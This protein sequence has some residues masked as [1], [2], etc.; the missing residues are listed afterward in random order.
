MKKCTILI[1][2]LYISFLPTLGN[3]EELL[4]LH[5][6]QEAEIYE[7]NKVTT[8]PDLIKETINK[9]PILLSLGHQIRAQ[10]ARSKWIKVHPDPNITNAH[11]TSKAPFRYDTIGEG[12]MNQVQVSLDQKFPFPGKLKL[13]GKI[14]SSEFE[15]IKKDYD[16]VEL[17]LVSRLKK[18]YYNLFFTT[19]SL[20]IT[21]EVKDLLQDIAETVKA[22]YEVG[23]GNQHDLVKVHLEISTL[24]EKIEIL[25][26]DRELFIAEINGVAIRPQ[27]TDINEIEEVE[28][29]EFSYNAD[30]L[31]E[32]SK[33]QYP[34]LLGQKARIEKSKHGVKLA[35]KEYYPDFSVGAGYGLRTDPF[36]DMYVV[37]VMT[38]IPVFFRSKQRNQLKESL[39]N[40]KAAEEKLHSIIVDSEYE[41]KDL[42]VQVEKHD[43]VVDLLKSGIIPQAQLAVDSSIAAYKVD[44]SD[45]LNLLDNIR[46]LLNFQIEYYEHLTKYQIAIAE[47]EPLVGRE[48]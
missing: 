8:L 12:P 37:Q 16:L 41:I 4:D 11:S 18:A 7:S 35:K 14:E 47:L 23:G 27:G 39:E 25:K 24:L 40:L 15:K 6:I 36:P 26:K 33:Q 13:K 3:D 43:T 32:I 5:T 2:L 17:K 22:K 38:S 44:S 34:L 20:E 30:E 48:I 9:N 29:Q 1:V 31:I 19:R 10:D 45:F 46:A 28:K 21:K 42:V